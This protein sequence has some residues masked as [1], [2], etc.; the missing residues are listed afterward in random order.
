M[1]V[2][3][4]AA[5][6]IHGSVRTAGDKSVSH[7]YAMLAG[8]AEGTSEFENFSSSADCASTLGCME[9]LGAR[10][11]REGNRVEVDGVGGD[12]RSPSRELDCG[13]SGST[14]RMLSGVI[15]AQPFESVM[16]GDASLSKRPMRRVIDPLQ[17]MGARVDSRDGC[18]PLKI[19]GAKLKAISY[20]SPVPSAQVKSCVL[21]AGLFADGET[22]VIEKVRTRDH[23]ELALKAFGVEVRR[24]GD[25]VSV[26]GGQ[27]LHSVKAYVPG[28]LSSV[29]FFLCAAALFPGSNLVVDSVLLNPTRSV[30]LDVLAGMG[31]KVSFISVEDQYGELIGTM[32]AEGGVFTGG[33]IRGAQSAALIDE[34]P[35]I[36]AVAPYSA[37]GIEIRDAAELRVK[38]S[39]RIDAVVRNLRA[40]GAE[41][42]EFPDGMW[43][44]GGQKLHGARIESFDDHRIAM[45]F[46]VAALRAD[47]ETTI[48]GAEAVAVSFPE[49]FEA[50]SKITK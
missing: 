29:T 12:L 44:P 16:T 23:T 10:V 33:V 26:R 9:A 5:T 6:Q 45:A 18:A 30:V 1:D 20:E 46:A 48:G 35:A 31:V 49:F 15:A 3:V 17:R 40:M 25:R 27:K 42:E 22:S 37:N 8:I 4:G 50:L 36:A 43:I 38:E 41:I 28:D 32:Q 13:N 24:D 21:L 2:K 7:R 11:R 47:G 34:L 19:H 39:D 14:M